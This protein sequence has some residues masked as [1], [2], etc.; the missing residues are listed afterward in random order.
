MRWINKRNRNKRKKA[1]RIVRSFIDESWSLAHLRHEYCNYGFFRKNKSFRHLLMGEQKGLC[2]YCMRRMA[3]EETNCNVTYEHVMPHHVKPEDRAF[4]YARINTFH[5]Q[6]RPLLLDYESPQ[7]KKRCFVKPY[8]HFCAYENLVLSCNGSIYQTTCP[9]T[10]DMVKLHKTCNLKRG[11]KRVEPMFFYR[12][13]K[14]D[15]RYERDGLITCGRL[16]DESVDAL[17]L[18]NPTLVLMRKA[19]ADLPADW[20]IKDVQ[21]AIDNE[22][23]RQDIVASMNLTFH[24]Q[25]K[26]QNKLYWQIFSEYDWFAGYYRG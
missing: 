11:N 8:P 4:Y 23:M 2:C 19:W 7:S 25:M 18:E 12:L 5:K 17:D 20:S 15:W 24:E 9:E 10:E 21:Q 1:H 6:V 13:G 22:E 3:D 14:R 26:L 16:F